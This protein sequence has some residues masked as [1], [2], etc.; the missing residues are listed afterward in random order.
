VG[1]LLL[2]AF[3][4][5]DV[6]P[7]KVFN[8]DGSQKATLSQRVAFSIH[9]VNIMAKKDNSGFVLPQIVDPPRKCIKIWIPDEV[10]HRGAFWGAIFELAYAY[11][12]QQTDPTKAREVANLWFDIWS[13]ATRE[14]DMGGCC[15]D[16][17]ITYRINPATGNVEQSSNGGTTY[18]PAAGGFQSVIVQPV[19][20]VTS[21]VAATKCDAATNVGGQ[22]NVWIDQVSNDF[23]TA[24]T[25]LDFGLAVIG[26][27]A[28][29]VLTILTDGVLLPLAAQV[30]AV[31]GAALNAAWGAGKV[32]FDNYWT[33]ENRDL[34]LCAAFCH[35]GADGSFTAA[36]FSAFWNECNNNLPPSPAK[37]LFMGFLSSVGQ[38]GLNAMA[39][40]GIS[41]D[42]DCGDCPCITCVEQFIPTDIGGGV[43]GGTIIDSGDDFLTV[44]STLTGGRWGICISTRHAD[45]CCSLSAVEVVDG[46]YSN[47][48]DGVRCGNAPVVGNLEYHI[49]IGESWNTFA[50]F[51]DGG[52][53]FTIKFTFA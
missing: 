2:T 37:M 32:V 11:N 22:V 33:T 4:R 6:I 13:Q 21:G 51:Q 9:Q 47:F 7:K 30:L 26:A 44:Q 14:N 41:A 36:Q 46:V 15:T 20:P 40:S 25:L 18:T 24:T 43:L 19:P 28:A 5:S 38:S 31:L 3:S 45:R 23:T 12:W 52:S 16:P 48:V 17:A 50:A 29:A 1:L 10:Y 35:I 39:A 49:T 8:F 53:S 27:I 34:V 42:S